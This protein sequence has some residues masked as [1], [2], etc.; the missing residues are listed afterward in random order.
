MIV[1]GPSCAVSDE[2]SRTPLTWPVKATVLAIAADARLVGGDRQP[3]LAR[4]VERDLGSFEVG[5]VIVRIVPR[6]ASDQRLTDAAF[7]RR[8]WLP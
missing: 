4:I 2:A 3:R 7:R 8:G 5:R 6:R 1:V